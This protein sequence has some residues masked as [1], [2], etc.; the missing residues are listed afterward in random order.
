MQGGPPQV[1]A[2]NDFVLQSILARLGQLEAGHGDSPYTIA[3]ISLLENTVLHMQSSIS[4]LT[5]SLSALKQT[6]DVF[7]AFV[8]VTE[9]SVELSLDSKILNFSSATQR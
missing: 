9:Q 7:K 3:R 1:T 2:F 6:V 5:S 4:A 8:Q